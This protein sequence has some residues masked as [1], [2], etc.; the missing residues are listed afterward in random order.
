MHAVYRVVKIDITGSTIYCAEAISKN[1]YK[2]QT[3]LRYI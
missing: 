2:L 3:V 1:Q